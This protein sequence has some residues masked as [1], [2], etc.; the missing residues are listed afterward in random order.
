[1]Y[2]SLLEVLYIRT[3]KQYKSEHFLFAT[4]HGTYVSIVFYIGYV[5]G[6]EKIDQVGTRIKYI[7]VL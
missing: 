6:L 1:M 2:T 5:T 3:S 4:F 7:F